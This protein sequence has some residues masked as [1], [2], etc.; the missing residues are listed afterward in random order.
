VVLVVVGLLALAP[1]VWL[2]GVVGAPALRPVGV[3]GAPE[4]LTVV[5][6]VLVAPPQAA[7]RTPA[8]LA[9]R[10]ARRTWAR[11]GAGIA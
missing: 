9:R 1:V 10:T 3:R 6:V 8:R 4:A 11:T 5:L 7:I 2:A